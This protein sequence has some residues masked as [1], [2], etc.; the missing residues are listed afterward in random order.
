MK[1]FPAVDKFWCTNLHGNVVVQL[2]LVV[3]DLWFLNAVIFF[4]E[5]LKGVFKLN[6]LL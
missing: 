6:E 3:C 4:L 1:C 2:T 5:Y